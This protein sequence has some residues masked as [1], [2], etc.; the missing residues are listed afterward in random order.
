MYTLHPLVMCCLVCLWKGGSS[1][2]R[3]GGC[4]CCGFLREF[5]PPRGCFECQA[6]FD[7]DG[8]IFDY[9]FLLL[10]LELLWL[11]LCLFL[12][13]FLHFMPLR[14]CRYTLRLQRFLWLFLLSVGA[15]WFLALNLA[16]LCLF[17][18]LLKI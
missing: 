12:F 11:C 16:W 9:S 15:G 7:L 2:N 6:S 8:L 3:C 5:Q 1:S 18:L 17:L 14:W 13:A 10:L 4:R